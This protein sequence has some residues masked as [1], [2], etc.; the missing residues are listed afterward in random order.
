MTIIYNYQYIFI[1]MK[2]HKL[3]ISQPLNVYN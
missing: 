2:K 1:A 3:K